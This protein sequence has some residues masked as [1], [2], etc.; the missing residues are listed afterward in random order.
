MLLISACSTAEPVPP[1]VRVVDLR[2]LESSLFEQ[3]FEI[4]LSIGNPNDFALP[5]DGLSF[6]LEV[7]GSP[8]ASGLSDQRVTIPR[9]GEGRVSVAASTTLVDMVRQMLLLA[10]RGD[11]TYRLRGLAYM[12]S[13]ARRSVPFESEGSFHLSPEGGQ[14]I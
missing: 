2:L 12:D 14:S 4:D 11:I 10:E 3:R 9:L 7:N 5:L 13:L 8:F 6:A 1:Q